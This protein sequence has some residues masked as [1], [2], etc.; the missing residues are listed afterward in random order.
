MG[1]G[2]DT[3][4]AVIDGAALGLG[5]GDEVL[6]GL[7]ALGWRDDQHIGVLADHQRTGEVLG[8]VVGHVRHDPGRDGV[9]GGIGEDGVAIGLRPRHCADAQGAAGAAA[10]LDHDGLAQLHGEEIEHGAGDDIG[11]AAG[12]EGN[13]GLDRLDRP[14]WG[15]LGCGRGSTEADSGGNDYETQ[16][17]HHIVVHLARQP[18]LL[19]QIP[20]QVLQWPP[21]PLAGEGAC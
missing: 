17:T 11:R 9:G 6:D 18:V 13:E 3:G 10:I 20:A 21:F 8:G 15:G 1:R 16:A 14:V 19:L 12:A 4:G 2:A 7:P 5:E